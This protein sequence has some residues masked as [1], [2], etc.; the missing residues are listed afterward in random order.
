MET[1]SGAGHQFPRG[2]GIPE[3]AEKHSIPIQAEPGLGIQRVRAKREFAT[4][5]S[6]AAVIVIG[7]ALFP[8][9]NV[10]GIIGTNGNIISIK[11]LVAVGVVIRGGGAEG[12]FT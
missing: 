3:I 7:D 1:Y 5:Y 9:G 4:E 8:L 11:Q 2:G 10:A 6:Q 12:S